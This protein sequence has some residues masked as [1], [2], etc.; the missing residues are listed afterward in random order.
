[1]EKKKQNGIHVLFNVKLVKV[2]KT[3]V[4]SVGKESID[5]PILPVFVWMGTM[6]FL[7]V[8]KIARN[9]LLFAKNGKINHFF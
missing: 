3:I 9:V 5:K 6:T 1:M 7:L 2:M 8:Q 4:W